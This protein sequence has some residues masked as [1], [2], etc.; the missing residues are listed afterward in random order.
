[1]QVLVEEGA[2]VEK[3]QPLMILEAM[4]MEHTISAP[5]KGKVAKVNFKAGEQVPE[6]AVLLQIEAEG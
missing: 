1:V 5:G 2:S 3:G 4:K 6:G